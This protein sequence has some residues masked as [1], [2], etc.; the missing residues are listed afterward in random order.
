MSIT[1]PVVRRLRTLLALVVGALV[2]V[3]CQVDAT[4]Q[5]DVEEDGSG[6]VAVTVVLDAD[7]ARRLGDPATAVRLDDLRT[8]GWAVDDPAADA[9]T[10]AV[11]FRAERAFASPDDLSRVLQEVGGG[12]G[13]PE[14]GGI[15]R[16]VQLEISDGFASTEYAFAADVELSGSLE[17]FSDPDLAAALGG[18]PLARTPEELAAEAATDPAT[19]QLDVA[20]VLPGG[21]PETNGDVADGAATWSFPI[22]GGAA[23]ST[24]L[25]STAEVAQRTPVVLM[26]A[27]A[28]LVVLALLAVLVGLVRRRG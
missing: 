14:G 25:D 19:V 18:L 4:V 26:G 11:T 27:G 22:T 5:I 13:T 10:G 3:A 15:F 9:A 17:Q 12:D 7:A 1:C 21:E 23:T 20:V 2:L 24:Q 6:I 28:V 8:A 16:Q